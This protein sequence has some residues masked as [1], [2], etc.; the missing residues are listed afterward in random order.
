MNE[1]KKSK[2]LP[3][4][5]FFDTE[6]GGL[7]EI[8][9]DIVEIAVCRMRHRIEEN[10]LL[11]IDTLHRYIKPR[12]SVSPEAAKMNGYTPE[13]WAERGAVFIEEVLPDIDGLLA[14]A[15]PAGQNPIFD[16]KFLT[17][18]YASVDR[19]MP[20]FDYHL[21]DVSMLAWPF[22]IAGL[23]PGQSLRYSCEFF[24]LGE[25]IHSAKDDIDKTI[26]VYVAIM[27]LFTAAAQDY[28][29]KMTTDRPVSR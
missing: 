15:T 20:K 3:D 22:V 23:L 4:L 21:V 1:I 6:T 7:S 14:G 2:P 9:H 25:Q 5:F 24:N 29:V 18:A 12:K 13:L 27:G 28:Y 10:D 19:S 8:D 11:C 26:A 17:A 16:M